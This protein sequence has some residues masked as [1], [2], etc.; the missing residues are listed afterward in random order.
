MTVKACL[1]LKFPSLEI[2]S[3]KVN[4][5]FKGGVKNQHNSHSQLNSSHRSKNHMILRGEE[6]VIYLFLGL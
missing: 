6:L 3:L 1:N 5:T 2:F 4:Y